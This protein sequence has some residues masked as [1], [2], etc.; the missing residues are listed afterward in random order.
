MGSLSTA[1]FV[2]S[3]LGTSFACACMHGLLF[4]ATLLFWRVEL[5]E[6]YIATTQSVELKMPPVTNTLLH[7]WLSI[8]GSVWQFLVMFLVAIIMHGSVLYFLGRSETWRIAR[9]IWSGLILA[10][11]MSFLVYSSACMVLP[12]T[13]LLSAIM[14]ENVDRKEFQR[15]QGEWISVNTELDGV[16]TK[17]EPSMADKLR[18]ERVQVGSDREASFDHRFSWKTDG[19]I[20]EGSVHR[21][22]KNNPKQLYFHSWFSPGDCHRAIYKL[23]G[24][25]LTLCLFPS[26]TLA[27]DWSV[28][29]A[30][31]G[32]RNKL[33]V[34]EKQNQSEIA[35]R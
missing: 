26:N 8:T 16:T 24:D 11:L 2:N 31:K 6:K 30:T 25:R 7:T 28:E 22:L 23:E 20:I 13:F 4:A 3:P 14:G 18:F 5:V 1:K 12:Y 10:L 34:F 32:T 27:N 9:E 19:K 21:S 33:I 35:P 29:F 15:L 17:M